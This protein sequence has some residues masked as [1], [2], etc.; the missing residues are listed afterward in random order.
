M[1]RMAMCDG[2]VTCS[3]EQVRFGKRASPEFNQTAVL[4]NLEHRTP[5]S[6]A[7]PAVRWLRIPDKIQF[8][9]GGYVDF[10]ERKGT[11]GTLTNDQLFAEKESNNLTG[12]RPEQ[13]GMRTPKSRR[14]VQ[15][16]PNPDKNLKSMLRDQESITRMRK[17]YFHAPR[18]PT[19]SV[20][21]A[22][23]NNSCNH[24]PTKSYSNRTQRDRHARETDTRQNHWIDLADV[25][26]RQTSSSGTGT[27]TQGNTGQ[28]SVSESSITN[29]QPHKRWNVRCAM[30][31]RG[32]SYKRHQNTT[33]VPNPPL[34][35]GF[36]LHVLVGEESTSI[37]APA[38]PKVHTEQ[39]KRFLASN[40]AVCAPICAAN[41]VVFFLATGSPA[42]SVHEDCDFVHLSFSP[43]SYCSFWFPTRY[44]AAGFEWNKVE[45][46]R[47]FLKKAKNRGPK[48]SF[49]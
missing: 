37:S 23:L 35:N 47:R 31:L 43:E 26:Q 2:S 9:G 10:S 42:K 44:R 38:C 32:G 8:C 12:R 20:L 19:V 29:G 11:C 39:Q 14:T 28:T 18:V 33:N 1:L 7:V 45:F 4:P 27:H 6:L 13:D 16:C 3:S 40:L 22:R 48:S 30:N 49:G 21:H 17:Q 34:A 25:I 46:Q 36:A 24:G 5:C 41:P 15:R